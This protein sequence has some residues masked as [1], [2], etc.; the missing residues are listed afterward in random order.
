MYPKIQ[1]KNQK[2]QKKDKKTK[3]SKKN[4]WWVKMTPQHTE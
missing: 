4:I 2:N 1:K 3:I